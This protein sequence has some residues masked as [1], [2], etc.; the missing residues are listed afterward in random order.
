MRNPLSP[1]SVVCL[2][3]IVLNCFFVCLCVCA[4]DFACCVHTKYFFE[5]MGR[6]EMSSNVNCGLCSFVWPQLNHLAIFQFAYDRNHALWP[7]IY[8]AFSI[9]VFPSH[10]S[11]PHPL[12]FCCLSHT[13]LLQCVQKCLLSR[14]FRRSLGLWCIT[15]AGAQLQCTLHAVVPE[16]DRPIDHSHTLYTSRGDVRWHTQ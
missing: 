1:N 9:F 4:N 15:R 14:Y 7:V 12:H 10:A 13:Y 2:Q 3:S 8:R 11:T 16:W 6:L 5:L